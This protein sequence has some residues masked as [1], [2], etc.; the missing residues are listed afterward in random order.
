MKLT[1]IRSEGNIRKDL[2]DLKDLVA[3][4]KGVGM[5]IEPL[6]VKKNGKGYILLAGH[7]RFAAAKLAGLSDVPVH[8]VDIKDEDVE[9]LQL[10]ENLHRKDLTPSE[11]CD[12]MLAEL[13]RRGFRLDHDG[14]IP[15]GLDEV[16]EEI[17]LKTGAKKNYIKQM[18]R[19]AFL[20]PYFAKLLKADNL[21]VGQALMILQL[22]PEGQANLEKNFF[23]FNQCT[24]PG[25]Y[26][27][28]SALEG[29]ISRHYGVDLSKAPFSL[30]EPIGDKLPC[31]TCAYNTSNT[32]ELF[33]TAGGG[34]C[35]LSECFK[36]KLQTI[37]TE[38][39]NKFLAGYD[40]KVQTVPKFE[41]YFTL[42]NDY[43]G[44]PPTEV[45]GL[46][47]VKSK[48]TPGVSFFVA[49]ATKTKGPSIV[50]VAPLSS[51]KG[52]DKTRQEQ[53][54]DRMGRMV[55]PVW[56]EL[57]NELFLEPATKKLDKM[58]IT[59]KHLLN[60][61][62]DEIRKSLK[63]KEVTFENVAKAL[64]LY[65]L[66]RQDENACDI[67][68]IS[69]ED[70]WAPAKKALNGMK[71]EIEAAWQPKQSWDSPPSDL[72]KAVAE[73]I[74]TGKPFTYAPAPA[75]PEVV[76]EEAIDDSE[77]DGE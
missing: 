13:K 72:V 56:A 12:T 20:P 32:T 28:T 62:G 3:S 16:A 59:A 31:T 64:I 60:I 45:K 73:A 50:L 14:L 61:Q 22:P 18:A 54:D 1:D 2:G 67:V 63:G 11:I 27:T 52:K 76:E 8:I 21:T 7:R 36:S 30:D 75:K 24:N 49:R 46:P 34:I 4:I 57:E 43:N 25:D 40:K 17:A 74:R 39:K 58:T 23:G 51:K 5:V 48:D 68:G 55:R 9:G 6:V 42:E 38:C 10:A 29:F 47:I 53:V 70:A 69:P 41:G 66:S 15:A 65:D 44:K 26:V 35:R 77:E 71:K 33:P 37:S 19:L